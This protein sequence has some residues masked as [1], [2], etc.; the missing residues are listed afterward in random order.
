MRKLMLAAIL[1]LPGMV[2]AQ[3]AFGEVI[4]TVVDGD[5]MPV[6]YALVRTET[7]GVVYKDLTDSKGKFRISAVPAGK[8]SFIIIKDEDTMRN[9][10][11]DIS[12]DGIANLETI[13]FTSATVLE[14]TDVIYDRNAIHLL[15]YGVA[16]EIKMTAEDVKRSPVKFD[17]AAMIA[18]M[19][20]DVKQA[21]DGQLIFRGARK[22][23]M[24]YMIDG[25]K[26]NGVSNIPSAAIG[27]VMVYTGGIPAK[28]GDTTGGVVVME[29]KS[30]FDLYREWKIAQD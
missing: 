22:G 13:V 18:T 11:A 15:T 4:G 24:I 2:S 16:P 5:S 10:K 27:G 20:S 30:Y 12:M 19:T 28:Y 6:S 23:D 21:D 3:G 17:Q 14:T 25:V 29:T 1:A 26:T 9:V 8:Y 7:N